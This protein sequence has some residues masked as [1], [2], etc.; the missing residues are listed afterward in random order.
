MEE[1]EIENNSILN[2]TSRWLLESNIDG[3]VLATFLAIELLLSL[4]FNTFIVTQTLRRRS[5][6]N[7]KKSSIFLLFFLSLTNLLLSILYLPLTIV[8]YAAGEWIIGPTDS[9]RHILCQI[10]GFI[11]TY[12]ST[13]AVHNLAVI[14]I[15]RFLSITKPNFHRKF[16]SR[17]V[18]LGILM[19]LWVRHKHVFPLPI[20][21]LMLFKMP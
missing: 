2:S 21:F 7:L 4:L 1:L 6:K 11:V 5:R 17:K 10:S 16:M 18:T 8:A 15:D 3:P 13:A 20:I 9:I 19:L 12:L 14:S